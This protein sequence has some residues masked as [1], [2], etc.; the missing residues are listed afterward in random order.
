MTSQFVHSWHDFFAC[1]IVPGI[2][3]PIVF[4]HVFTQEPDVGVRLLLRE[5]EK[6]P[7]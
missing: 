4:I 5:A 1:V 7:S 6:A 3:V 2:G